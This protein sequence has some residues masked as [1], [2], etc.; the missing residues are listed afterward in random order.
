MLY[1]PILTSTQPVFLANAENYRVYFTLSSFVSAD[2]A[3]VIGILVAQQSNN[4]SIID[5]S[6]WP[7]AVIY[8]NWDGKNN[9][10][11]ISK[12]DLSPQ[13]AS[14]GLYKIQLRFGSEAYNS[15]ED[16]ASW[17][18][19]QIEENN[20]SEW[21][22]VM[23]VKAI[24]D[25]ELQLTTDINSFVP[26]EGTS[27]DL[28][29][30]L[31]PTFFGMTTFTKASKE[32]ETQYRI[33]I[34]EGSDVIASTGWLPH[35][36]AAGSQDLG[37]FNTVLEN[38]HTYQAQYEIKSNNGYYKQ[39]GSK[40]FIAIESTIG[41]IT[42]IDI[43]ANIDQD[44]G[45]VNISLVSIDST[46]ILG[47]YVIVR[48]SSESNYRRLED[49]RFLN[50][51]NE[52]LSTEQIYYT[53]YTV[54]SGVTY[55]YALQGFNSKEIRTNAK[56]TASIMIDLQEAYLYRDG[57]QLALKFNQKMN[58]FKHTT[59]RSKQDTIGDKYPHLFQ[60]GSAYYAEFPIT[61]LISFQENTS[62]FFTTGSDG[63][64]YK[65]ELIIP[66]SKFETIPAIVQRSTS[67]EA[68]S[69]NLAFNHK[70]SYDWDEAAQKSNY[71][72]LDDL[73]ASPL[74]RGSDPI[75]VVEEQS[76]QIISSSIT[77]I[78]SYTISTNLTDNNIYIE[79][80]FREKVEEFLNDFNCKLYR[81]PT[82]GN[83]AVNLMN[84]SLTPEES[85]GRMIFSFT[86]TAYEVIEASLSE[87]N[88]YGVIDI[89]S[90]DNSSEDEGEEY[91]NFGQIVYWPGYSDNE[92]YNKETSTGLIREQQE[93]SMDIYKF[94]VASVDQLWIEKYSEQAIKAEI[95]KQLD[96]KGSAD[97][98]LWDALM[99][100]ENQPIQ[101]NINNNDFIIPSSKIYT[102]PA[103]EEITKLQGIYNEQYTSKWP[104]VINYICTNKIIYNSTPQEITN[105]TLYNDFGQTRGLFSND[106]NELKTYN[107]N[108][109]NC[110][111]LAIA[112]MSQGQVY[113]TLDIDAAVKETIK[114]Q[115]ETEKSITL[116]ELEDG[117]WQGSDN[118]EY[119]F[120][121]FESFDVEAPEGT[122]IEISNDTES[123]VYII[124]SRGSLDLTHIYFAN[125]INYAK[126]IK[127]VSALLPPVDILTIAPVSI[128]YNYYLE[129]RTISQE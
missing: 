66:S 40:S 38:R 90:K 14:G 49:I 118:K 55:K 16:F 59:L 100:G 22:T 30:S 43:H 61:G 28:I 106:A 109:K 62:A 121:G 98:Y 33:S 127:F 52:D 108:Y 97:Q 7:D 57:V 51:V 116:I 129:T 54:E 104:I 53:D 79:R 2:D 68:D 4:K 113:K 45:A 105:I 102:T 47:S 74:R 120:S 107:Y 5:T 34:S 48:T 70:V 63:M 91:K 20:F 72:K 21:S 3:K 11:D 75:D 9:Y 69:V 17:H 8:Q 94:Q 99:S 84:V 37:Y 25:P 78:P 89:G 103:G 27:I 60:N 1:P 41:D 92:I 6:R 71:A 76:Q 42:N 124:G 122:A 19:R 85:L 80:K 29:S 110:K 18:R 23:I 67:E 46:P 101:L 83:I 10:V 56:Y 81:S 58:S 95:A 39:L 125:A 115:I 82:E 50:F 73:I 86:A 65:G 117:I 26:S 77:T 36:G 44:N 114:Q 126:E 35:I 112:T 128:N 32:V 111:T 15:S 24:D 87:L 123:N 88:K 31:T 93:V 119:H 96:E 64:Y 13:W 12:A